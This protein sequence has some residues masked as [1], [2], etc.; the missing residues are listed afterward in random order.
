MRDRRVRRGVPG[1]MGSQMISW[2]TPFMVATGFVSPSAPAVVLGAVALLLLLAVIFGGSAWLR[3]RR[4]QLVE[5]RALIESIESVRN[6]GDFTPLLRAPG[7]PLALVSDAVN[8][9]GES[10]SES[11]HEFEANG[12]RVRAALDVAEATALVTTD[13]D[14]DV[15]SFSRGATVLFG[16]DEDAVLSRPAALLFQGEAYRDFLP[17]LKP[18]SLRDQGV[19]I[20]SV[21]ARKDGSSFPG[22]LTIRMLPE[23]HLGQSGFLMIVKDATE[24]VRLETALR[25]SEGRYRGLV[26]GLSEGV[27]IVQQGKLVVA[28]P[29]FA[30]LYNLSAASLVG[31]RLHELVSTRDVLTVEDRVGMLEREGGPEQEF[32]VQLVDRGGLPLARIAVKAGRIDYD[33]QAAVLLLAHDETVERRIEAEL[34]NNEARLDAVIEAMSDGLLVLSQEAS[35]ASVQMTNRAFADMIG[36]DV[37]AILGRPL[38][39]LQAALIA[40]DPA[41]AT[42]AHV[43]GQSGDP[44]AVVALR[45]GGPPPRDIEVRVATLSDRADGGLGRVLACRDMTARLRSET[46]LQAFAEQ[47][48][49]SKA[50]LEAGCARLE[51]MNVS[52]QGRSEELDRLNTELQS[53]NEMKTQLLGNVAHELQTPLVS[54]R[55]Y[56][57]MILKGRLGA[58]TEEQRQGLTLALKNIDRLIS[59]IDN[60]LSFARAQSELGTLKLQS[61]TLESLLS[62]I[63]ESLR[64]QMSAR[65]LDYREKLAHGTRRVYADREKIAQVLTNVLANAIKFNRDGGSIEI[66]SVCHD[67][68]QVYVRVRDSGVGIPPDKLER[69]FERSYRVESH[70]APTAPG[71][72]LGLAIVRD[73][74]RQHGCRVHAESVEGEGTTVSFTL[75]LTPLAA[76]NPDRGDQGERSREP[77]NAPRPDTERAAE[78]VT[79]VESGFA[80]AP[81]RVPSAS[82]RPAAA[83]PRAPTPRGRLRIIRS[84]KPD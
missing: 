65:R 22:S 29:A 48:Q 58:T 16:W 59:M 13:L 44:A 24:Q 66:S 28:N 8:R 77:G 27:A 17:Q 33:G 50:E 62:E 21:L 54:V 64:E 51:S 45:L 38:K 32:R 18:R 3:A 14:G 68:D 75:P 30:R 23:T 53:L 47:L 81:S 78:I 37:R 79:P 20:R 43:L 52:L 61:F 76:P 67:D 60:L 6:G 19:T 83:A 36:M 2:V 49:L 63:A 56:T 35:G 69:I 84:R 74:L 55:G 12:A 71:S 25:H 80:G 39:E 72:G 26:E 41:M 9:L 82:E 34:R 70:G 4:R 11:R 31:M 40:R 5:V 42:L 10:V 1:W 15:T 7:S 57:E 73:I 46:E